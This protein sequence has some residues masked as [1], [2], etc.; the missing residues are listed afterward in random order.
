MKKGKKGYLICMG[1][2]LSRA[3]ISSFQKKDLLPIALYRLS[4]ALS[5]VQVNVIMSDS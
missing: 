3:K 5:P 1:P 4:L 2:V